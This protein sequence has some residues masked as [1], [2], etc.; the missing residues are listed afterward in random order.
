MLCRRIA[1]LWLGLGYLGAAGSACD[2]STLKAE[3]ADLKSHVAALESARQ[4]NSTSADA[5]SLLSLR[6]KGS[7][8][9]GGE[10]A[11]DLL[12]MH[13]DD[14][15]PDGDGIATPAEDG[16]T[17]DSTIFHTDEAYLAFAIQAN[18]S[19]SLNLLLDLD[20][21]WERDGGGPEQDDLLEECYFLWEN[22]AGTPWSL[23]FGKKGVDYGMD[24]AAGITPSLH[25]EGAVAWLADMEAVAADPNTHAGV[26]TNDFPYTQA[27]D[28]FMIEAQYM[29]KELARFY[30]SLFQNNEST[31]GGRLT[32]GM[33]EDRSD[34]TLLFQSFAAKLE[35]TPKEGLMM[36]ASVI[37]WH[38]DS[39]GDDDLRLADGSITDRGDAR[40]DK[41]AISLGLTY[42]FR[43]V[44]LSTFGQYQH[45]WNWTYNADVDV[46]MATLGVTWHATEALDLG[47]MG[48]WAEIDDA[49][50]YDDENYWQVAVAGTYTLENGIYFILEYAHAWYDADFAAPGGDIDREADLVGL[51]MG[52]EF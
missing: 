11:I 47:L 7:V 12:V 3:I 14:G 46:D 42:D 40:E 37:H 23:A 44:P 39:M 16:D 38:L 8:Q 4:S 49:P 15:D 19:V 36:Q 48:E 25:E 43:A 6:R 31:G 13:R 28:L 21:A 24:D 10:V 17:I 26:G 22:I 50:G 27:S 51:R 45:G 52:W 20:D 33:H 30:V 29:Y 2:S 1:W 18:Q 32:R 35:L 34:D 5:E 9:I 41:T